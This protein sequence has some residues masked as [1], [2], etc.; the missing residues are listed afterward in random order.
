MKGFD[1]QVL[2]KE[3]TITIFYKEF[4]ITGDKIKIPATLK[5][6]IFPV[7]S[8]QFSQSSFTALSHTKDDD[9]RKIAH[10]IVNLGF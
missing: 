3:N 8:Q 10:Q 1:I 6:K 5:I 4:K 2:N 7:G 9:N